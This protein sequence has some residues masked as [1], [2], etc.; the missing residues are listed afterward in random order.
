MRSVFTVKLDRYEENSF[1]SDDEIVAAIRGFG[2]EPRSGPHWEY[3][4]SLGAACALQD[5]AQDEVER[6]A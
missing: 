3:F 2:W 5:R 4:C 6:R 1:P